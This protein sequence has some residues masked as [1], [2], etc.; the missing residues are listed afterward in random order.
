[1]KT[2]IDRYRADFTTLSATMGSVRTKAADENMS[3]TVIND[4]IDLAQQVEFAQRDFEQD[5][6]SSPQTSEFMTP[7]QQKAREAGVK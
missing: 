4:Q 1:M 5:P 6:N 7:D 3:M 2:H